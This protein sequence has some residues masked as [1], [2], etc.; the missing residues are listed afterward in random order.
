MTFG[1]YDVERT[2]GRGAMGTVYL[3]RDTRIGRRVALKTLGDLDESTTARDYLR[4][5]QREA[6]VCGSLL[7]PNIVTFYEAGYD[8]ERISFLAMEYIE[9][10]TLLER[11]KSGIDIA[12]SLKIVGDVLQALTYAHSRGIIHRDIK[13]ANVLI[14]ADGTAKIADFGIARPQSSSL[15]AA[16]SLLG[17]PNYMSPEQVLVHDLTPKADVFSTG[18]MLFEMLTGV[19]P[20]VASDLT[21]TLHNILRKDV[22]H[23]SDVNPEVPREVGDAIA[24]MVSK[25]PAQR[26]TAEEAAQ[27]LMRSAPAAAPTAMRLAA[28]AAVAA[29]AV[30]VISI[31]I[32]IAATRRVETP[33]V[34]I[35]PAKLAEFEEKRRQ[36]DRAE[37]AYRAGRYEE[38]EKRFSDYLAKYP[39]SSAAAE[40]RDRAHE[41][42]EKQNAPKTTP[43]KRPRHSRD[44]D[45]SP[46]ELLRRVKKFFKH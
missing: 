36:L 6:E 23:A 18:V 25:D 46:A 2:L 31:I 20:F 10:T 22:P 8:G 42:L 7:H 39:N 5:L 13:P 29:I 43:A 15:T 38:S 28:L 4:R 11:M 45:I 30:I 27:M 9:G 21:G 3:A 1:H 35:T 19:K 14:A 32:A 40:G 37:E 41:A 44:E 16:G 24:R 33:T 12:T 34:Q 17:T 26:P